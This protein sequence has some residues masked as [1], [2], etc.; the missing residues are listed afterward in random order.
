MRYFKKFAMSCVVAGSVAF[1]G[2]AS[3]GTTYGQFMTGSSGGVYDILG[4]AMVN[5]INKNVPETR[6]NPSNP[7]S[8]SRT[9]PQVN[10]GSAVFGISDA[11]QFDKAY[12]GKAEFSEPLKNLRIVT[13]L[14]SNVM[15]Q[16][17]LE[18][19][20]IKTLADA[21]GKKIAVPSVT[22]K[23]LVAK[24]YEYAGVPEDSIEW[25]YLTYGESASALSDG[26][27]D[28]ATF[29]G[30]PKNG[31]VES[32][33]SLQKAHFLEPSDEVVNKWNNEHPHTKIGIIPGGTYPGVS[34]DAKFY[35]LYV[36]L[37]TNK[38]VDPEFIKNT[39]AAIYDHQ[40]EIAAGHPA[41]Q[42]INPDL[43]LSYVKNGLIDPKLIAEGTI[44]Y[45]KSINK[46]IP[47][48]D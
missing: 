23:T 41:G 21:K 6:L 8:Y 46:P 18:G 17:T 28:V 35:A 7:S 34:S 11:D 12:N 24:M 14:Y 38:D 3:G 22:T 5:V 1:A 2:A 15:S 26:H 43:L 27:V 48:E 4:S 45:Y 42:Q 47:M 39:V 33:A 31:T 32:I 37:T 30:F 16:V 20:G 9:P 40:S 29:T 10:S 44:E 25:V 36:L 13:A 19:S